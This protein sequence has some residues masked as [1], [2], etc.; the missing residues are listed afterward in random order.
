ML[1]LYI[2]ENILMNILILQKTYIYISEKKKD[3]SMYKVNLLKQTSKLLKGKVYKVKK[4]PW[5][6]G[7]MT[8]K[9]KQIMCVKPA[10]LTEIQTKKEKSIKDQN[11]TLI[12]IK[13]KKT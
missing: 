6:T 2:K 13:S 4:I 1:N 11:D 12:D 5:S 9:C 8:A 10:F 3:A 7:K